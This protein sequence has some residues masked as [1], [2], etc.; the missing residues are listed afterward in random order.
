MVTLRRAVNGEKRQKS[1][2]KRQESWEYNTN[3][4]KKIIKNPRQ[5]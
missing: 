1:W 4:N 5:E 2:E 3:N